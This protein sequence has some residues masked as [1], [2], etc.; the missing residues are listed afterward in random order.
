MDTIINRAL[1]ALDK[2]KEGGKNEHKGR[3]GRV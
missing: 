2:Q 3:G 1:D